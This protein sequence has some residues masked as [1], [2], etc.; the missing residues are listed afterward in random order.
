MKN[1][2]VDETTTL[3][4]PKDIIIRAA[5][6]HRINQMFFTFASGSFKI[7]YDLLTSRRGA[8]LS[9]GQKPKK[10]KKSDMMEDSASRIIITPNA[11]PLFKT[12]R[13]RNKKREEMKAR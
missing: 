11:L 9:H 3:K 6:N 7:Y 2:T 13:P 10:E 1:L 8:L 12:D 4:F 5:W